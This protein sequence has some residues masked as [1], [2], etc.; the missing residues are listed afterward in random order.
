MESAQISTSKRES[1]FMEKTVKEPQ[2]YII[3]FWNGGEEGDWK[4]FNKEHQALKYKELMSERWN[5]ALVYSPEEARLL[6]S[7]VLPSKK[8]PRFK[9]IIDVLLYKIGL[10]RWDGR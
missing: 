3:V 10:K 2:A 4:T 6:L 7:S 5:T 8:A 1:T 9:R